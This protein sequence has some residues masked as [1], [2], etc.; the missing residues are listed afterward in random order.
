MPFIRAYRALFVQLLKVQS[1]ITSRI[2]GIFF[3]PYLMENK[4][5]SFYAIIPATV[6]YDKNLPPRAKL[7]FA[8]ITALSNKSGF[9]Y[10]SNEYFAALYDVHKNS[11]SRLISK[12]EKQKH[13]K[14]ST[15]KTPTGTGR[16]IHPLN[17]IVNGPKQNCEGGLTKTLT[18]IN[19]NVNRNTKENTITNI[20]KNKEEKILLKKIQDLE[21][22]N[23]KLKAEAKKKTKKV[24][25]KKEKKPA[26]GTPPEFSAVLSY[27]NEKGLNE[28]FAKKFYAFYLN[29][30]TGKFEKANGAPLVRW[31]QSAASWCADNEKTAKYQKGYEAPKYNSTKKID[32][33]K[34]DYSKVK[35]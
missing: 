32:F 22:E 17:K 25:P 16:S 13:I 5:P 34:I 18:G 35:Y 7:L 29:E 9:C 30:E 23:L 11:I 6:R 4:E 2:K 3:T 10:A 20:K 14:L 15:F 24:A 28:T 27:F 12:L 31:K 21:K 8:E 26:K 1:P 19:N 33:N